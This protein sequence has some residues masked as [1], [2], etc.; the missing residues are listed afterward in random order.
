MSNPDT[1]GMIIKYHELPPY[2]AHVNAW[3]ERKQKWEYLL[4]G[5]HKQ[6]WDNYLFTNTE[7]SQLPNEVIYAMRSISKVFLSCSFNRYGYFSIGSLQPL[8]N[9]QFEILNQFANV[10]EQPYTRFLDLQQAEA[11]V[12]EALIAT[13]S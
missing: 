4:E 10:F 2:L 8:T 12:R 7:L 5:D 13:T 11:Q 9:E 6:E 1:K 3:K